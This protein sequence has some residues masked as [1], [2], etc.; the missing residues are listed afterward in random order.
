MNIALANVSAAFFEEDN[1]VVMG[2][3]ADG[4]EYVLNDETNGLRL[5]PCYQA[6]AVVAKIGAAGKII[7][8][9]LW[10]CRAPYGTRAWLLDGMEERMIEDERMYA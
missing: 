8:P 7:N 1:W 5:M 4:R 6:Q 9:M 10:S 2:H 3:D